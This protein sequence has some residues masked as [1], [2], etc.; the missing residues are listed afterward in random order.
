MYLLAFNDELRLSRP[1]VNFCFKR[2]GL[3]RPM[4]LEGGGS[5]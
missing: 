2:V 3:G 1:P 4:T 5:T